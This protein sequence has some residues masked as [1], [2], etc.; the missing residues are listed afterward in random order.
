MHLRSIL[1]DAIDS[2]NLAKQ[3]EADL[4]YSLKECA[5][6]L[7]FYRI[8]FAI[9]YPTE[10]IYQYYIVSFIQ[11]CLVCSSSVGLSDFKSRSSHFLSNIGES[12]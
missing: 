1:M 6:Y 11:V 2:L 10:Y 7:D 12:S 4:A 9:P 8:N 3:E 5:K